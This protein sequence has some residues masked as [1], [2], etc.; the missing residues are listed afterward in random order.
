MKIPYTP[1]DIS[2]TITNFCGDKN[3]LNYD[4]FIKLFISQAAK[5]EGFY[6][7]N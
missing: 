2:S 5:N 1:S 6:L 3:F 4:E 7:R